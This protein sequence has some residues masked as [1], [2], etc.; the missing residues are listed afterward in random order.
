MRIKAAVGS[1][2]VQAF[3][4]TYTQGEGSVGERHK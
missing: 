2:D 1:F 3:T 4:H